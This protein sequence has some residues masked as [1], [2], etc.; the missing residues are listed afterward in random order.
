MESPEETAREDTQQPTEVMLVK[1]MNQ[2]HNVYNLV[3]VDDPLAKV[4]VIR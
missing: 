1:G 3:L 4:F 2:Y